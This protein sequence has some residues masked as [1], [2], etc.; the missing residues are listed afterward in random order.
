MAG[1][2]RDQVGSIGDGVSPRFAQPAGIRC[3]RKTLYMVDAA[4]GHVMPN[5]DHISNWD[6]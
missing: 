3:E 1:G 2:S 6:I 5:G 4:S